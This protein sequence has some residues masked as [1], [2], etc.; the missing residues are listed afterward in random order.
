MVHPLRVKYGL[1]L[2]MYEPKWYGF[3]V[4]LAWKQFYILTMLVWNKVLSL[5]SWK[6]VSFLQG[7]GGE[8]YFLKTHV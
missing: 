8:A 2:D 4:V 3:W 7:G 5:M 1:C 6:W